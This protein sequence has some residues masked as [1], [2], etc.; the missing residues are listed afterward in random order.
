MFDW[1]PQRQPQQ[2]LAI[3]GIVAALSAFA[4]VP[5]TL[6]GGNGLRSEIRA[7]ARDT[8]ASTTQTR[9][10]VVPPS[11][12]P[13]TPTAPPPVTA[14]EPPH[15]PPLER[16]VGQ[17]GGDDGLDFTV[18][19][20]REV[21][22]IERDPYYHSDFKPPTGGTLINVQV[23]YVNRTK[24]P[25]DPFCGGNSA[26]LVDQ[27]GR[28]HDTVEALYSVV[29]NDAVCGGADTLPGDKATVTLAFKLR[30]GQRFSHLDL[31]NGKYDPDFDGEASRVRFRRR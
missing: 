25:V 14:P 3:F 27:L 4:I 20:I 17:T 9:N 21:S 26:G 2:A 22:R 1:L 7:A 5:L 29:G 10:P 24:A 8:R 31:W 11:T 12:T 30:R 6:S 19:S 15:R 28:T 23:T 16:S 18:R 13:T